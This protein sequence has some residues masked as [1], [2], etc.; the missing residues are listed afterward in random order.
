M[1]QGKILDRGSPDELIRR[2]VERD[3]IEIRGNE[4]QFRPETVNGECRLENMGT[5]LY[6]YT[7]NPTAILS[8]LQNQHGITFLH[9]PASLEDVFLRLTGRDLRD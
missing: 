2:H 5:S 4:S 7:N 3:V 6:C 8:Q 1:D 9:R